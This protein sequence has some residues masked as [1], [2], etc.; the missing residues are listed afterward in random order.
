MSI[1][2]R[3]RLDRDDFTLDVDLLLPERGVSAVFGPSGSGKTTLLRAVAGLEPRVRGELC[4]GDRV[5]QD[6]ATFLPPH[7]RRVGYVFQEPSL[8]DH[9]DV[10]GN[11][12]YGRKRRS[13]SGRGASQDQVVELL[14]LGS[15]LSRSPHQ[16]SGGEKQRVAVGRAL[17]SDPLM[18]L[19]DEPL[20]ALDEE[21]KQEILPYLDR[22]HR[23]LDIPVLYVSHS[24]YE[25]A[26]LAD[27]LALLDNGKCK[28]AGPVEEI[29]ARL[30]LPL[31]RQSGA[32]SVITAVVAE[33]DERY[34]LLDLEFPGGR[35]AVTGTGLARG[36]RVRVQVKA[37]DVSLTLT[38]QSDTSI[39]NIFPAVVE[40]LG[41]TG[42][43]HV[44]VRVSLSGVPLLARVTAKSAEALELAPGLPV[45][46]QV[47]TVALVR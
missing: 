22:L 41:G 40:E 27:H 28:V 12:E 21:L 17:A 18:L 47:K 2:A 6:A 35:I 14:G 45:F 39:L 32:E 16:L 1:T 23:E 43:P 24:R 29:Y 33:R 31:S 42:G 13:L 3:L 37:K 10:R 8:F 46:A 30:D 9:L 20:A 15:L 7:K 19:L 4:I 44:T 11:L 5:W 36:E 26:R 34:G 38:R 25:V